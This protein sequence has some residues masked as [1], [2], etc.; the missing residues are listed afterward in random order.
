MQ[1]LKRALMFPLV[2]AMMFELKPAW[3][4]AGVGAV[5]GGALCLLARLLGAGAPSR[6]RP[7]GA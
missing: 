1:G 7:G 2:G 5:T 6:P 3:L 4:L